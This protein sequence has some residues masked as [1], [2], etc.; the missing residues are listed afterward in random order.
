MPRLPPLE[1]ARGSFEQLDES[2][3][4]VFARRHTDAHNVADDAR[5]ALVRV[6]RVDDKVAA[7]DDEGAVL[8]GGDDALFVRADKGGYPD[9]SGVFAE[10][11]VRFN[12]R[13]DGLFC[14]ALSLHDSPLQRVFAP[15]GAYDL[16]AHYNI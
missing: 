11:D 4:D 5:G 7:L 12:R 16:K 15:R 9:E 2:A 6:Q 13:G 10:D 3:F 8:S 1:T 14:G